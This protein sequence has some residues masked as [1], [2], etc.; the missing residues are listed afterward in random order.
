MVR[1]FGSVSYAPHLR[2]KDRNLTFLKWLL[3]PNDKC[4]I[5]IGR[6]V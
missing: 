2:H 1:F 5:A 6:P 4:A 3:P